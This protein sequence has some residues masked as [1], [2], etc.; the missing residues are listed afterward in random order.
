MFQPGEEGSAA[1][2]P[3]IDEGLLEAA[4]RRVDAAYAPAR[5]LLRAPARRPG[6]GA[7]RPADGRGRRGQGPRRRA[8]AATGRSRSAARTRSRSPARW[9]SRCR[10]WS[11][12]Q[13]DIF[14]PVVI[15]VGSSSTPG[16]SATSSRTTR[17]FEATV[18]SFD[19]AAAEAV[20]A[21]QDRSGSRGD[22][23][24]P[25][26]HCRGRVPA[27]Y[28]VTVNDEAEYAFAKDTIVDLFGPDRYVHQ[29]DP[30]MGAEDFAFV[31]HE[32]PSAYVNLSACPAA[33]LRVGTRQPLAPRRLRRLRRAGRG[34]AARRAGPPPIEATEPRALARPRLSGAALVAQ[35]DSAGAF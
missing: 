26:A 6:V 13:F 10:P 12:A 17:F 15:A 35:M 28:P 9:S 20:F 24:G 34:R 11:P 27:G 32:V 30:E 1:P 18:R 33:R 29:R 22:R 8:R 23:A 14:D 19:A 7:A 16:P 21:R 2:K 4:G 31:G 3:M 5:L 25:R